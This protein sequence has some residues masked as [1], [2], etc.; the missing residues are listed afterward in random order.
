MARTMDTRSRRWQRWFIKPSAGVP[1]TAS[2]SGIEAL[3]E[4]RYGDAEKLLLA[5]LQRAERVHPESLEHARALIDLA[6][7]YRTQ[8]RYEEA[9]PL[10][11]RAISLLERGDDSAR[12]ALAR[13]LNS[14]ALVYR[15]QGLYE[16][17]EPLCHRALAILEALNGREHP[18]TAAALGNLLTIYL[19]QGRYGEAGPLFRRSVAIKERVL[20]PRHPELAGSLSNYAA[21]LRKTRSDAEAATWEA[22]A[23][24]LRR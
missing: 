12:G 2:V 13:P 21:F 17:A 3:L 1:P 4:G 9:E 20:G 16:R 11:R 19:A 22:R 18:S 14:L 10:F 6:E 15:A 7:L 24:A 5:T 23:A 8:A